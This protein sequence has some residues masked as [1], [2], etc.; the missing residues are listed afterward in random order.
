MMKLKLINL[1]TRVN[2]W[3]A[4]HFW[5]QSKNMMNKSWCN[6]S[7]AATAAMTH[8]TQFLTS[9]LK[10]ALSIWY[11]SQ[12]SYRCS[13]IWRNCLCVQNKKKLPNH[14]KFSMASEFFS[15]L[16]LMMSLNQSILS[17][18]SASTPAAP[19]PCPFG[20]GIEKQIP[21]PSL[22]NNIELEF[23]ICMENHVKYSNNGWV[24]TYVSYYDVPPAT[25]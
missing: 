7:S 22:N 15:I 2:D 8:F 17:L 16:Y 14:I 23:W 4:F 18:R 25:V 6:V 12:L 1:A 21:V 13:E 24:A 5:C 3:Q 10:Y 19:I 11:V 20:V 9:Y